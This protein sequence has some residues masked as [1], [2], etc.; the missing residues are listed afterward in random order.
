MLISWSGP[1]ATAPPPPH[2]GDPAEGGLVVISVDLPCFSSVH[3][4]RVGGS[5]EANAAGS[6]G[7]DA[8]ARRSL[9]WPRGVPAAPAEAQ[10]PGERG[11]R[12]GQDGADDGR[13]ERAGG[14]RGY[15]PGGGGD[16][17][18]VP[19][20]N[21]RHG[22]SRKPFVSC[23]RPI[24]R[25]AFY[26]SHRPHLLIVHSSVTGWSLG[27]IQASQPLSREISWRWETR[28]GTESLCPSDHGCL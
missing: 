6:R 1:P 8:A 3:R 14:R 12:C 22:H 26:L 5:Q 25:R 4:E 9:C 7:Q 11:R 17:P 19:V 20:Q 23:C 13:G 10:R 18:S 16:F 15:V 27:L 24:K 21:Q 28:G 2:V